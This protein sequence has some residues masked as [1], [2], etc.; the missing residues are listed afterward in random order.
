MLFK[1]GTE[2][3]FTRGANALLHWRASGLSGALVACA[4]VSA[5]ALSGCSPKPEQ[6]T[7]FPLDDGRSWTYRVTK[8]LD[9]AN[10][11]SV[12]T[13]ELSARG[14]QDVD[15]KPALRRHS[16]NGVDYWFRSDAS[17]IFRIASKN[18]L[19]KELK[20]D[21]PP[22]YVLKKPYAVG[23]QWEASTV[24]YILQRKNEVPKEIRYTHKP[25][26]MVYRIDALDQKVQTESGTFEGCIRV[27]GEAKIKLYVDVLFSWRD[28]PLFSTEWYCPKVGLVRVERVE[29]S[30]SRTLRGGTMTLDLVQWRP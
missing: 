12:D 15:G 29:T 19:D 25:V 7:Y 18:A 16:D 13:L 10:E 17:G 6:D 27:L 20:T 28:M 4:V 21:N 23:T 5:L 1:S 11:P 26:M 30:P 3:G 9:E 24:A 14:A 8:N 22:R 2:S